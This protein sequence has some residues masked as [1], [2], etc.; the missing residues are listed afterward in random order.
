MR[1]LFPGKNDNEVA[2]ELA[3][4][5][6]RISQEFDPLEPSQIPRSHNRELPI[7]QAYEV[8][9]RIK[10]FKKPRSMVRGDIFP[11]LMDRYGDLL[12]VPL[13]DIYNEITRTF[14]WPRCWKQEFV[15]VIPKC[16]NPAGIGDLRNISCTMLPSKV[17][18]SFV[19]DWLS[20]EVKC[21]GNQY[22][23]IKG[24][25]VN[26]LLIDLWNDLALNLEDARAATLITAIDYAKAFNRLSFQHC[27]GAFVRKGASTE[28]VAL[29]ATFLS[30]RT[31]TVRV[32]S[33]WSRPRPVFGGVPQGSILGVMLFNIATDD[34]EDE[35][36]DPRVLDFSSSEDPDMDE[37]PERADVSPDSGRPEATPAGLLN[38]SL[39][40]DAAEFRPGV[41]WTGY[42]EA[43]EKVNITDDLLADLFPRSQ[44]RERDSEPG[45]LDNSSPDEAYLESSPCLHRG[46][47]T[48]RMS[49]VHKAGPRLRKRSERSRNPGR[50]DRRRKRR[51]LNR[52][53]VY[54]SEEEVEISPEKNKKKTGLRWK[55]KKPKKFKYVDDGMIVTKINMDSGLVMTRGGKVYKVKKDLLSQNM[56]RRVV[57]R[58][59]GR[60]MVVNTK[61]TKLLCISDAQTYVAE[62]FFEDRDSV[63]L[64]SGESI[65][66]LGFHMDSRP[67]CHAH[68]DALRR[69]MRE[70]VWILRHL[71]KAGFNKT[72]LATV[73]K[74]V[75]RPVVDYCSVVYHSMLTDEQD[76]QVE[77][78]QSQA[79]KSIYGFGVSYADMR[80]RAGVTTLRAR[81]VE[82]CDKFARKALANPRYEHWFPER[83]GRQGRHAEQFQ[84]LPARTDRLFNS[85]L[86]YFRRR[87]N[88]KEGKS[89]GER[90]RQYRDT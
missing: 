9:A 82:L 74:T 32:G 24:S 7:L 76:Q 17:Y 5:F 84:E 40:P 67:T 90:N 63:R 52:R 56:F 39:S 51:N 33:E 57:L 81:R 65:K 20:Q 55:M 46:R 36:E 72:E 73:Y 37:C 47:P 70:R 29:L 44:E 89:Y 19:L 59:T 77:R 62:A 45:V 10:S 66:I 26:H 11:S 38:S 13:S 31:M 83:T 69:R 61:K 64:E 50:P 86:F 25:S 53:I 30:N 18:E 71:G 14:I 3:S 80:E 49:P 60:G 34:L 6:N 85:P 78:L 87:L 2:N 48:W 23:G 35:D 88:G 58:A 41:R 12:A 8:A 43:A 54:S 42:S 15:T 27:L 16:R 28:T 79:L 21:K 68:V 75:I 22:G 1:V 4:F